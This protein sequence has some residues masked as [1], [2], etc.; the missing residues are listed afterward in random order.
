MVERFRDE[1]GDWRV[2]VHSPF[3]GQVHAPW[4]LAVGARLRERY[5]VD[6]QAMHADDGIVIRL[7]DTDASLDGDPAAAE[8]TALLLIDPDDVEP[9]V[10]AEAG[11]SALFASRFREC[12]ARALLLPRRDPNRRTP[13]WQQRQRSAQLLSVAS[14][15]SSFP[16]LLETMREVLQDVYDVPALRRLMQDVAA[17][18]VR[19]VEVTTTEPSPFARSLLFGYVGQF[20][21]EGDSP[22][23]ERRAAAL[24]LDSALLAELLGQADLRELLDEGALAAVEAELQRL[25]D[26]RRATSLEGVADLLRLLGPLSTAE[27]IERG[28]TPHWLHDLEAARRAIRVRLGGDERWAAIE[29]SGRLRDA[30]GVPLPVGVPEAF[31]EVVADPLG[32]LVS[33]YARTHG[34]FKPE[35]VARRYG[36]GVAV[37]QA[38]LARMTATGRLVEGELRPGG[39]G[40]DWC[41]GE[42]LRMLRR[43]SLAVLRKEAEPVPPVALARFLPAWQSVGSTLTGP[44]GVLRVVEQLAGAAVPASALERLVLPA[45]VRG[46]SPAWLDELTTSGEVVWAGHGPL[47]GDDGWVSL[48]PADLASVTVTGDDQ[49]V[50]SDLQALVL[51][52]LDGDAAL[53]FR[54]LS[55]RVG[56]AAGGPVDDPVLGT[57]LWE[58]VWAGLLTNDTLAPLRALTAGAGAHRAR[59]SRSAQS[60]RPRR[61]PAATQSCGPTHHGGPVVTAARPRAGPDPPRRR[62]GRGA[63]GPAR[64]RHPR[65]RRRRAGRGRV[66]RHLP[67]ALR[68][69]GH[70]TLPPRLRRGGSGRGP[71]RGPRRRRPAAGDRRRPAGADA[72]AGAGRHRPGEPLRRGT[73]LA[74]PPERG[75]RLGP[76]HPAGRAPTRPARPERSSCSSTGRWWCTSSA[77]AGRCC[78]SATTRRSCSRRPTRSRSP[79]TP[80]SWADSRSSARTGRRLPTLRSPWPWPRPGSE[81]PR[82]GCACGPERCAMPEGDVVRRTARRLDAALAGETL[83]VADLRVPALAT[84]DLVG[85]DVEAVVAV[86]KHLLVR[87]APALTLH[88]HLRMDGAWHVFHAGDRWDAGPGH[89]IRVVLG[90]VRW[91]AVG[92]RVHDLALVRRADESTLVGHLGPDILDVDFDAARARPTGRRRARTCRRRGAARPTLRRGHRQ[93]VR[94]PRRCSCP[95]STPGHRA[96]R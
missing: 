90:D 72:R 83:T 43:R 87:I 69:R 49:F 96:S 2:V 85:H 15:H 64:G 29:D 38:V 50:A 17:R 33:R 93:P 66:R 3:G 78:R 60:L 24:A 54:S 80:V 71:V 81:P 22:L 62:G 57:A 10:T 63:A 31:L 34:P 16:I 58:L 53:F 75:D 19:V 40:T 56:A 86:G 11:G 23:A 4:A 48:H 37:V 91:T 79:C 92:Y 9:L 20:L 41:D 27:A 6:V 52:A 89:E 68:V 8:V 84:A 39:A 26:E 65:R 73:P 42:V 21:Y 70:R 51:D 74:R 55:D 88:A 1:L 67:R 14:E 94:L 30:L 59:R 44:E 47:P 18:T 7:P 5:G 32:D 76:D 45:R 13:L 61:P 77:E 12:A 35:D 46:Y 28:A 36:L 82:A 95:A 25:T